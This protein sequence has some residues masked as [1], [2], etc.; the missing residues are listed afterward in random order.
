MDIDKLNNWRTIQENIAVNK[1]KYG[2]DLETAFQR[3]AQVYHERL[4]RMK[5][6]E[7]KKLRNTTFL[8]KNEIE[9]DKKRFDPM[10][11]G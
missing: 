2:E 11:D 4:H 8:F 1:E 7:L 9:F 5:L 6:K 10:V 3:I